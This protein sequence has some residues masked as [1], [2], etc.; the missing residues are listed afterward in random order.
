MIKLALCDDQVLF[1]RGLKFLFQEFDNIDVIIEATG[2][3]ELLEKLKDNL[4]DVI[5]MDVKMPEMDGVEATRLV[6]EQY[7]SIKIILLSMYDD[8]RL[9]HHVIENGANGYLLKN[10]EPQVVKEA[11]ESVMAKDFYFN[12]YVSR[13]LMTG[14]QT[15]GRKK[16]TA[17][18]IAGTATKLSAREMEVLQLVC[19]EKTTAEIAKELF[20]SVR[21]VEGHRKNLIDKTGVRNTA[22]LVIFAIKNNLATV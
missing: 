11:I 5:L 16:T 18:L 4:P 12:D 22:G 10:E 1:L 2:G 7:P 13:A 20:I 19:E 15:R 6:K 9:I 8:E 21:T 3:K 14:M 17:E